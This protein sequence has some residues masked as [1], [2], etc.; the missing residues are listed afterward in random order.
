MRIKTRHYLY[1]LPKNP[2]N[3]EP[4]KCSKCETIIQKGDL[5]Y[6]KP[7]KKVY[8]AECSFILGFITGID[9][10]REH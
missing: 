7:T 8:C 4:V 6:S 10:D 1:L 2:K 9:G 3:K 5:A